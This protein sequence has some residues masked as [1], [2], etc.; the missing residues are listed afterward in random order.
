[1]S[2]WT[3]TCINW[4]RHERTFARG[5]GPTET[6]GWSSSG[7]HPAVLVRPGDGRLYQLVRQH[8]GVQERTQEITF[9]MPGAAPYAFT[10][11]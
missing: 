8:E 10:F 5:R 9:L 2:F 7:T 1:V 11:G 4:L 3:L 6:T